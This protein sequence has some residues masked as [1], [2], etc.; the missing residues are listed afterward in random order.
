M[1]KTFIVYWCSE[2]IESV[3]DISEL[4]EQSEEFEKTQVWEILKS[5]ELQKPQNWAIRNINHMIQAMIMRGQVNPDRNY[6]IYCI[7]TNATVTEQDLLN[8]FKTQPQQTANIIREC[9]TRI[10]GHG[11]GNNKMVI[12]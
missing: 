11:A 8:N 1:K 9:G 4:M 10:W 2:G 6:E 12:L 7:H 5:P 3:N